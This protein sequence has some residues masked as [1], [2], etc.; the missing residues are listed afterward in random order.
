MCVQNLSQFAVMI[1]H[2]V[3]LVND[4]VFPLDLGQH[5]LILNNILV[6]SQQHI[7]L[8]GLHLV[9]NGATSL[10]RAFVGKDNNTRRP[11]FHF[12][13]PIGKCRQG[14]NHQV[15]SVIFLLLHQVSYQSNGLDGFSETLKHNKRLLDKFKLK[16]KL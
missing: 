11:L 2:S 9:L 10:G 16:F 5:S 3:T 4:H 13:S 7:K 6:S 1:L 14:N 8:G 15:G 12:Q